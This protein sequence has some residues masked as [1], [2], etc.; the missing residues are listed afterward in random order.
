LILF[1]SGDMAIMNDEI[2][3]VGSTMGNVEGS[4]QHG[5]GDAFVARFDGNGNI[6]EANQFGTSEKDEARFLYHLNFRNY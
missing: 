1:Y 6:L 2:F 4:F 3:I 5:G